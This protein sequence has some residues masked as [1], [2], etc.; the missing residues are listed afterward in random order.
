MNSAKGSRPEGTDG[1]DHAS[2]HVIEDRYAQ[3]ANARRALD[4]YTKALA[5]VYSAWAVYLVGHSIWTGINTFEHK[6]VE[7]VCL[8]L[9]GLIL[10]VGWVAKQSRNDDKLKQ[11]RN[12]NYIAVLLTGISSMWEFYVPPPEYAIL[13]LAMLSLVCQ[14]SLNIFIGMISANS[15]QSAKKK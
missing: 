1:N 10:G 7:W 9:N 6:H 12:I 2:R 13:V 11:W 14:F 4:N 15:V 5:I 8:I 3:A